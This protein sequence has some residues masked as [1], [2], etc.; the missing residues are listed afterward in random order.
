MFRISHRVIR[1]TT[2]TVLQMVMII[3]IVTSPYSTD[4]WFEVVGL[5]P[6][7]VTYHPRKT[8]AA[9][10]TTLIIYTDLIYRVS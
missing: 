9:A 4:I 6:G 1:V 10:V 8:F 5:D 2:T 3:M 7:T